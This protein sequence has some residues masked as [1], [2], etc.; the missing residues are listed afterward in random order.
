M[1]ALFNF[2]SV[3]PFQRKTGNK[4]G[5]VHTISKETKLFLSR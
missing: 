1:K 4:N 3:L 5:N 2:V